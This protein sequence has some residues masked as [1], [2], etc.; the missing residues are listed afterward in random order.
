MKITCKTT[1]LPPSFVGTRFDITLDA[2]NLTWG[3]RTCSLHGESTGIDVDWGDGTRDRV[4]GSISG[5]TH[6]YAQAGTYSVRISDDVQNMCVSSTEASSP[7][8]GYAGRIIRFVSTA[9]KARSLTASAFQ[10]ATRLEMVDLSGSSVSIL[11]ARVFRGCAA[12]GGRIDFPNVTGFGQYVFEG[13]PNHFDLHFAAVN[14]ERIESLPGYKDKFG[15]VDA[16]ISFD[17]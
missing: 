12:L 15:A 5:L 10:G 9:T 1:L 11:A 6:D 2:G 7:F 4:E 13:C 8:V 3:I 14:K 17:L 16:T